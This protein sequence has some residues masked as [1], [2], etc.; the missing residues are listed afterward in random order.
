MQEIADF[1]G[2]LAG[3]GSGVRAFEK[4]AELVASQ[5]HVPVDGIAVSKVIYV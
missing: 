1:P 4:N 2:S 3:T 5:D